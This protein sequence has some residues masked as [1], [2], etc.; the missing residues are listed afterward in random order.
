MHL[1]TEN[2]NTQIED[3]KASIRE[4]DEGG[5]K[6]QPLEDHHEKD[7]HRREK[8]KNREPGK[9]KSRERDRDRDRHRKHS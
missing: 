8:D 5:R 7:H 9:D 6:S 2:L 1:V 4:K 3:S